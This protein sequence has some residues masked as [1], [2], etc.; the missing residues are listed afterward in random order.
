MERRPSNV[1]NI[2]TFPLCVCHFVLSTSLDIIFTSVGQQIQQDT[3]CAIYLQTDVAFIF[4]ASPSSCCMFAYLPY[5]QGIDVTI[6]DRMAL[7]HM[8][9]W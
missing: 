8:A 7:D 1:A 4:H 5:L 2:Q 9:I 6:L 3:I